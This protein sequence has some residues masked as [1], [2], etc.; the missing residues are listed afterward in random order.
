MVFSAGGED[1]FDK[2]RVCRST[3][4]EAVAGRRQG[5]AEECVMVVF[6]ERHA[7]GILTSSNG[8]T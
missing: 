4:T 2:E 5:Y 3:G 7:P 8:R 6:G 1:A